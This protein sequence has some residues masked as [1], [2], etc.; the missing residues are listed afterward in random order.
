MNDFKRVCNERIDSSVHE[1]TSLVKTFVHESCKK[2]ERKAIEAARR[3]IV[4]VC[5]PFAT[6]ESSL[7]HHVTCSMDDFESRVKTMIVDLCDVASCHLAIEQ[8]KQQKKRKK[9]EKEAQPEE[10]EARNRFIRPQKPPK[11]FYTAVWRGRKI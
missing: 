3:H 8:N 1:L 10:I 11:T 2:I 6:K 7:L 4:T 9:Q 5:V